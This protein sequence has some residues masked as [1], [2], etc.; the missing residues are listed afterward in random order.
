MRRVNPI[1]LAAVG[2]GIL[3]LVLAILLATREDRSNETG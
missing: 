1:V 3:I 2:I